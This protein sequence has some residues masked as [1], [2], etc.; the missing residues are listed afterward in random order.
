[1]N[2]VLRKLLYK[3]QSP[4]LLLDAPPEFDAVR[5]DF[6]DEVDAGRARPHPFALAFVKSAAEADAA[7]AV[8]RSATSPGALIWVAYPKGTSKRYKSDVNRDTLHALMDAQGLIGVSLV[9][10]DGDWSAMR[11]KRVL[12]PAEGL[13]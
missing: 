2:A 12:S 13:S 5:R 6:G 11:F 9:S 3:S 4:V 8:I 10:I 1:V 7:A